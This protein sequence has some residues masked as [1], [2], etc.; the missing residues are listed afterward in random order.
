MAIMTTHGN[1]YIHS[2]TVLCDNA[3]HNYI[4]IIQE[5]MNLLHGNRFSPLFVNPFGSDVINPNQ[6]CTCTT[7]ISTDAGQSTCSGKMNLNTFCSWELTFTSGPNSRYYVKCN[8]YKK[9]KSTF[10]L[11]RDCTE[12]ITKHIMMHQVLYIVQLP[13]EEGD[14]HWHLD[15]PCDPN[16]VSYAFHLLVTISYY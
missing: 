1:P 9:D 2:T 14:V 7:Y 6:L 3:G 16:L 12:G 13:N 8:Y 15:M 11:E 4:I 10:N 5:L